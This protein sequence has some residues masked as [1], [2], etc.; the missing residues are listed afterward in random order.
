MVFAQQDDTQH[1]EQYFDAALRLRPEYPEALNNLGVLY[2]RTKRIDSGV[3]AF[4]TC[5]R[6]ASSFDQAYINLAKVY[7]LKGQVEQAAA[8]LHQLLE[9]HPDHAMARKLLTELGR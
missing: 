5:I 2:L 4:E 9:Q 3:K 8:V 6:V 7:A 1:A